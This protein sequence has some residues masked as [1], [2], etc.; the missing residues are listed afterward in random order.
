VTG[1][2]KLR[3]VDA[4]DLAVI[5]SVLQ[6]AVVPI[7]EVDFLADEARFVLVASRFRWEREGDPTADDVAER[8]NCGVVFDTVR[9]ARIRGID[10]ADRSQVLELLAVEAGEGCVTLIFSGGGAVRLEVDRL[11]CHLQDIGEPWPTPWRPAHPL[12]G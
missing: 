6:D 5:S 2:L 4:D 8:I 10:L 1:P 12:D 11:L 9:A 7:G 3:A